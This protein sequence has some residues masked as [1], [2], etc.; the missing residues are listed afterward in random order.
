MSSDPGPAPHQLWGGR[1][2]GALSDAAAELNRSLPVD[3]RLWRQDVQVAQ[4]WVSALAGAGIVDRA[5][6]R[7][8]VDGLHRVA[9]RLADGIGAHAPDEDVHTLVERLLYEEVGEPALDENPP[10]A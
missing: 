9:E 7:T 2:A 8:L 1:F 3:R 6:E 10:V 5:E 4:A